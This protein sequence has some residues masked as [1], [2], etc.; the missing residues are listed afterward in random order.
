[1]KN[2]Q[3]KAKM[4]T[5][6]LLLA[7]FFGLIISG[8]SKKTTGDKFTDTPT[9]G[10][11]SIAVD[12]TF[13]PIISAELPVFHAV[14]KFATI[15]PK[16]VPEAEAFNLLIKDSVRLAIVSRRL[17][18]KELDYFHFKKFFPKEVPVAVDGIAVIV[19]P[20]N[21]DTLFSINTLRKLMLGEITD[22][23]Q[24]NPKSKLG[25]IKVVFDNQNSSTVRFIVDSIAK[26]G[27]LSKQLS[28]MSYNLDVVDLVSKT[29]NA[30]GLIGVSWISDSRDPKCLSFLSKIKVAG[31][32]AAETATVGNSYQ[33]FQAYI[34]TGKYPLTRFI[35]MIISEPRAGL[36]TGFT[37]FVSSDK[38]QRIILKTGILPY[39]QTVRIVN[40]TSE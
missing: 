23:N 2:Y 35:Y 26:T 30:I 5:H 10:K 3:T 39:T 8:C 19:N 14:Y 32:S 24:L 36:G 31:I 11:A 18:A 1:M 12:E 13:Q 28:A 33:P 37:S 21:P 7:I 15:Q 16:Y 25:K 6:R 27:N 29:P 38:G 40:V 17:N 34:A 22:W 9:T 20:K 4:Y